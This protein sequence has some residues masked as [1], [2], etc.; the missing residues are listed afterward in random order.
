MINHEFN[1]AFLAPAQGCFLHLECVRAEFEE[2]IQQANP[3][4]AQDIHEEEEKKNGLEQSM[5]LWKNL[6]MFQ[7]FHKILYKGSNIEYNGIHDYN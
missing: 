5:R 7:F 6:K 1:L 3:D 4:L 2:I